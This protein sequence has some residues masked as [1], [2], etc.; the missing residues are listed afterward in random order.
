MEGSE[1][2]R[3]RGE[4]NVEENVNAWNSW[5]EERENTGSRNHAGRYNKHGYEYEA[6]H[7][8]G[9][10]MIVLSSDRNESRINSAK[11][12][13][14]PG[15]ADEDVYHVGTDSRSPKAP[16]RSPDDSKNRDYDRKRGREDMNDWGS[17][18]KYSTDA[19]VVSQSTT[20]SKAEGQHDG[21]SERRKEM[22]SRSLERR[23]SSRER[24]V[25]QGQEEKTSLRRADEIYADESGGSLRVDKR[26]AHR[27][28]TSDKGSDR[29]WN[30]KARDLEAHDTEW[31]NANDTEWRNAQERLDGGSYGR[32]GYRRD[33]RGR[34]ESVRGPSTYGN[35]Y[36][37]LIQ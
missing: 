35:R 8:Y 28:D 29:N 34:S 7:Q 37:I 17:S 15:S 6:G 14:L 33:S 18:R 9:D 32:A 24:Q 3:G 30:E 27:D 36:A 10:G 1:S 23:A 26:E 19:S 13:G 4:Q 11:T 20:R 16:R 12:S 21:E 25:H 31:R 5:E 22:G 2:S